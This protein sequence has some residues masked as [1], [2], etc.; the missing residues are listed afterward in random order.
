MSNINQERLKYLQNYFD[1]QLVK[2]EVPVY[3]SV[4]SKGTVHHYFNDS[5]FGYQFQHGIS[6]V[7]REDLWKFRYEN[8][9]FI[10][11]DTKGDK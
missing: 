4:T 5:R 9:P 8:S 3:K 11:H 2:V 7:T 10:I 1:N 6:W